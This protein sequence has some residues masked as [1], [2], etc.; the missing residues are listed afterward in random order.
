MNTLLHDVKH[1]IRQLLHSPGFTT[2]AVASLA[3]GIGLNTTLFSIVNAVLFRSESINR[4]DQLV[5]IYSGI[6]QDFPQLTTSHADLLDIQK[7][8]DALSSVAGSAYVR[9]I[10]STGERPALVTGEV[11]TSGYFDVL[12]VRLPIGRSFTAEENSVP[13][14]AAVAILSHGLWQRRFGGR[15]DIVGQTVKISGVDYTIVGVAPR[16][17]TGTIPGLAADFW[18]PVTMIERFVFSGVQMVA[19]NDPGSTRL[20]RRGTRWLFVKG[21]LAEGRTIEQARSQI[22]ALYARLRTEYPVTNEKAAASI[23]PATN[24]RFHPMLDGYIRAA[25]AG[26]M[27]AVALVLIV[28]CANVANMLLARGTSRRRELA[29]RAA[30]GATR[31]RLVRQLLSEGLVLAAAGGALGV[32]I[33]WWSGRALS[34]MI[35]D[36]LPVPVSFDFSIDRMV[37]GFAILASLSTAVLF[38]LVPALSSSKP[39]LVP[40]LKEVA[41]GSGRRRVTLRNVLVVSQ[42]ALSLVLLVAGALLARGLLAARGTE[43]GFDPTPVST[44]SFNLQMNGYDLDRA[45]SRCAPRR[46]ARFAVCRASSQRRCRPGCRSRLIS[47]PIRSMSQG[48]IARRTTVRWSIRSPSAPIISRLSAYRSC[49]AARSRKTTCGSRGEW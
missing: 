45:P 27:A 22:D 3:L 34:G 9:G 42:L 15:A 32:L 13:N 31:G 35:T 4:P 33:C 11:V 21:R 14:G 37:L 29:I 38:G 24:V 40:A 47:T 36:A 19:D 23:V 5:E 20:E 26:L 30:L 10:L 17:F 6:S 7:G 1:G 41:E 43:L 44:L 46:S 49:T 25:S 8:V 12:G 18:A 2:A 16:S 48:I 39:E 28:A